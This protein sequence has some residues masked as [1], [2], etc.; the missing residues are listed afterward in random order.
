MMRP[1]ELL[2]LTSDKPRREAA[3]QLLKRKPSFAS[4]HTQ[5]VPVRCAGVDVGVGG[6][7]GVGMGM[8]AGVASSAQ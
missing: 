6:G 2:H 5:S 4:L 3:K 8:R 7:A 1:L